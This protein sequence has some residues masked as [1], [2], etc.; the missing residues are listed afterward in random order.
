MQERRL[1]VSLAAALAFALGTIVFLLGRESGRQVAGPAP[2]TTEAPTPEPMEE[3]P[4]DPGVPATPAPVTG[5]VGG[6]TPPPATPSAPVRLATLADPANAATRAEVAS[7]F[8]EMD[9]IQA[10]SK[11]A[12]GD[13]EAVAREMMRDLAQGN[14]AGL[15]GLIQS[16]RRLQDR[17]RVVVAPEAC[18]DHLTQTIDVTNLSVRMLEE[19]RD[20][21]SSGNQS[22]LLSLSSAGEEIKRKAEE[23][24][25]L[26]MTIKKSYG[27]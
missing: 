18:R 2:E 7:Y 21:I 4:V 11:G 17:F 20:A 19:M 26:G 1:V 22:A 10:E 25:A 14:T 24:D 12:G 16:T 5:F 3:A 8:D 6:E 27:L 23:V 13:P 9:R 15:D